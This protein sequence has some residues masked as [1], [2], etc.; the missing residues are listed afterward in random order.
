M[1]KPTTVHF[2]FAKELYVKKRKLLDR[3]PF[4]SPLLSDKNFRKIYETRKETK[5]SIL[6]ILNLWNILKPFRNFKKQVEK[7]KETF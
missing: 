3:G 2:D 1:L 5:R 6:V 4:H 7:Q